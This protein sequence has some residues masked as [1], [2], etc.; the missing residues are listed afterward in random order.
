MNLGKL[1]GAGKSFVSWRGG[2]E[3]R[4]RRHG[5]LPKFNAGKNPFATKAGEATTAA[6]PKA[7]TPTPVK[8]RDLSGFKSSARPVRATNWTHKLNPFRS[9]APVAPPTYRAEQVE[10]SLDA[11]KPVSNDLEEADIEV[12]PVKSRP[13]VPLDL[14]EVPMLPP[15]RAPW[16]FVGERMVKPS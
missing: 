9:P 2:K 10:L 5:Y 3:Y 6:E 11:V 13:L 1:L 8:A 7:A 12:V 4:E 15:A 16:E 14:A